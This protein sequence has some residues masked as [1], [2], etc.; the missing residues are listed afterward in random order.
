MNISLNTPVHMT[1][2][3]VFIVIGLSVG[4]LW[5]I[6]ALTTSGL[7]DDVSA[8][9]G[10]LDRLQLSD[11]SG[12]VHVGDVENKLST[13]IGEL[14]TD[15]AA[16]SVNIKSLQSSM[17]A[18]SGQLRDVQKWILARQV[19]YNDPKTFELFAER[20]KKAGLDQ[21]KFVVVPLSPTT[22]PFFPNLK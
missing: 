15:I 6:F 2:K 13:Q 10:S 7:R 18:F 20:L 16:L 14:R 11:K 17:A 21:N 4:A 5:A 9:R 8:I 3:H 1:V 19:A 12:A 22:V